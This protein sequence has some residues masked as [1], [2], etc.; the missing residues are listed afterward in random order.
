M[1]LAFFA[2]PA[3]FLWKDRRDDLRE[4]ETERIGQGEDR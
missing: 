1:G 4:Q 3:F 2:L